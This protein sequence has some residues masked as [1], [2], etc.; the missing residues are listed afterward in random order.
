[1]KVVKKL[2]AVAAVVA[3]GAC[4]AQDAGKSAN[5]PVPF[6]ITPVLQQPMSDPGLKGY[7]VLAV[8]LDLIPGG[9]DPTPHRHDADLFVYV[10]QGSIEVELAGKKSVFSAGQMF[11]EPRNV[12]HSLLRN[13][14]TSASAAALAVF[15]LKDGRQ[16]FVPLAT[17]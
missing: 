13:T 16:S 11:H 12:V 4:G 14:S 5:P 9:S 6:T 8:R 3:S 15:I 7:Q 1:M 17:K 10:L 2:F